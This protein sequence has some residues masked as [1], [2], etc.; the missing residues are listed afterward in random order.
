[1]S[2][3][4]NDW[5]SRIIFVFLYYVCELSDNESG[6]QILAWYMRH[7]QSSIITVGFMVIWVRVIVIPFWLQTYV[8]RKWAWIGLSIST[9]PILHDKANYGLV[10]ERFLIWVYRVVLLILIFFDEPAW[11]V[12]LS[13]RVLAIHICRKTVD[14]HVP[15]CVVRIHLT[16]DMDPYRASYAHFSDVLSDPFDV[17]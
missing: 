14:R 6:G 5:V 1:M 11:V 12:G 15:S 8:I 10:R 4:K 16:E 13:W 2:I 9:F 17:W 3:W 7:F